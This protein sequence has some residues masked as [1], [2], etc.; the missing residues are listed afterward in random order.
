M[1]HSQ[2]KEENNEI[3][4]TDFGGENKLIFKIIYFP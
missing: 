4:N 1:I 2:W 3:L